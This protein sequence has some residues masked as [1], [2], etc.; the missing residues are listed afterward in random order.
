MIDEQSNHLRGLVN[1]L[2][3]MTRIEAG[4]L[5]VTPKP[6]DV[7]TLIDEARNAFLRRGATNAVEVDID[8][9]LPLIAADRRRVTQVLDNLLSNASKYSPEFSRIRVTGSRDGFFVGISVTDAGRGIPSDQLARLF[10]KYSR[11]DEGGGRERQVVGEGLGL[12]I[13]KGIVEAHGGRIWAESDGKERG[14]RITFT[15][16]E[17]TE[18]AQDSSSDAL[19]AVPSDQ[20]RILAVDDEPQVLWLLKNILAEQRYKLFG[21]GNPDEMMQMVEMEQPQLILLDLMLP[22]ANGFE[23]MSRIREVS[24]TPIIFL[25][26]NDQE[27]NVTK[28][29]TM[30][31]DDYIVKPFSSTE[32]LARVASSLRKRRA[33]GAA[34]P[35]QPFRLEGLVIDYTDRSVTISG[36]PVRLS[37]TEYKLLFE[38]SI[39]AGRVLT[40]DRILRRVWGPEYYTGESDLLRA[41]VKNLRRK[42]GDDA[43][44]P[45]YIFTEPRVGYRMPKGET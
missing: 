11:V 13:C 8:P 25:S 40:R 35:R 5:S 22:G 33:P 18:V 3:D 20:I 2:L 17:A 19:A 16:P 44:A 37:S 4:A 39:N 28:A 43:S 31:A 14:T 27:E 29:L 12:A 10:K 15:V 38:L 1:Y 26:A 24:E 30:G 6:M 7:S 21:T 23:L 34:V 41:T 32:L 42:L 45:R 36:R 9:D